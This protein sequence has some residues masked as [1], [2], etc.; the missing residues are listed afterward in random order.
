MENKFNNLFLLELFFIII[1]SLF[2]YFGPTLFHFMDYYNSF[3]EKYDEVVV[4]KYLSVIFFLSLTIII[5]TIIRVIM[6]IKRLYTYE[7][8]S[9]SDPLTNLFNR[10][11]IRLNIQKLIS[12]SKRYNYPFSI[13]IIDLDFFK[14]VNYS[15]GYLVGDQVLKDIS[16]FLITNVRSND[17]VGRWGGEEFIILCANSNLSDSINIA[18]KLRRGIELL[19]LKNSIKITASFGVSEYKK[20]IDDKEDTFINEADEALYISKIKGRNMV[21]TIKD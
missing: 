18:E 21:S 17:I 2:G 20:Y 4:N 8:L 6:I 7:S 19:Y 5:V 10:R 12:K 11:Y 15:Y 16:K 14:R 1:V 3:I 13:I 9:L